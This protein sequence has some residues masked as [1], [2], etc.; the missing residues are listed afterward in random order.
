MSSFHEATR[1]EPHA[2]FVQNQNQTTIKHFPY[3]LA[4]KRGF[5]KEYQVKESSLDASTK[6][7]TQGTSEYDHR[8]SISSKM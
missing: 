4:A 1:L 8:V 7:L 6:Y 2:H 3:S 5:Q